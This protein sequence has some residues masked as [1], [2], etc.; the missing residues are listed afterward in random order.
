MAPGLGR[1]AS[2]LRLGGLTL[3]ALVSPMAAQ[4]ADFHV[5]PITPVA[6]HLAIILIAAKLGGEVAVRLGQAAV[7]G[8]LILGVL[9]GN[10]PLVGID[11]L[12]HL[13][14]DAEIDLLARL[15]VL[16]LLFEIG[17]ESTVG[18]MLRV[19][20]PALLVA[21]F[22]VVAPLALGW[23]TAAWLLPTAGWHTHLFVGAI[24]TATSVGIS[25]RVLKDLGRGNSDEARIVLGAAVLDDI[26]GLLIMAVVAGVI[27]AADAGSTLSYADLLSTIAKA[28]GFLVGSIAFGVY[29]TPRLFHAGAGLRS[30]G[31]LLTLGLGL[32]FITAWAAGSVGLAPII[33]AFAGGLVL[34]D[35]HSKAYVSRGERGLLELLHPITGFLA[36]IFFV[37]MGVRT[38]LRAFADPS[39]LGLA[40]SLTAVAVAGKLVC[41]LGVTEKRINRWAVAFGMI[42]RGEVGLIFANLG[43]ALTLGGQPI[44][45]QTLFSAV[46]AMVIATT[47]LTPP[48]LIWALKPK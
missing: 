32:C 4:A 47:L 8:E 12:A 17:V 37:V 13:P 27:A 22:G 46:V 26:L 25:A 43:M 45:S 20:L 24:L 18:Q 28:L 6:L 31:V 44:V 34:E 3:G 48:A 10:L 23:G 5:D 41:A 42:P 29:I 14:G 7:V 9:L 1:I 2:S 11:T 36:P 38:D 39:T 33:G 15:G 35:L 16:L 21:I 30:P 19:G 40:F